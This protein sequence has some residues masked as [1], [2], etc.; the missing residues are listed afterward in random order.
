MPPLH[1]AGSGLKSRDHFTVGWPRPLTFDLLTGVRCHPPHG[2]P[3]S[4]CWCFLRLSLSSYE[5]TRVKLTTWRHYLDV[6][7]LRSSRRSVM[8]I[9]MLHPCTKFTTSQ[10]VDLPI[11]EIWFII[12][13]GINRPSDLD[14]WPFDLLV[15]S[16][17]LRC[18]SL[19]S[20]IPF[21]QISTYYALPVS[22]YDQALN[23]QTDGQTDK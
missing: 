21:C 22:T 8:R 23:R 13:H 6:W 12:S 2:Q 1:E 15:G 4:Q 9:F 20:W 5:Q 3:S 16:R 14:F 11:P 18:Q 17:V 19:V 10:F 7:S